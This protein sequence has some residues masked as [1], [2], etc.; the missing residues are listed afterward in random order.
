M[1]VVCDRLSK[2]YRSRLGPLHALRD[3]SLRIAD[4]EFVCVIGSSGCGK[5]TLL[6]LIAGLLAPTSGR[7]AFADD[8]RDGRPQTALVF[9]QHGLFPWLTV[10]ENVAFGLRMRGV[11]RSERRERAAVALGN[12][13]LMAFLDRYPHELSGGMRQRVSIARALLASPHVL[14]MDEP[15]AWLDALTKLALQE[16]LLRTWDARRCGVLFVT[17]DIDEAVR[18]GDR[19]I[20]MSGGDGG[21]GRVHEEIPVPLPRPRDLITEPSPDTTEIT[22]R[23]WAILED[24]VQ[25]GRAHI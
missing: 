25:I 9:Q 20:V 7:V 13:G 16:E 24:D 4:G 2:T 22:R 11:G 5:T 21:G 3:V 8:P 1:H 6:K 14:L 18:L 17:H 15:F 10:V 19:I 23:I 12:V